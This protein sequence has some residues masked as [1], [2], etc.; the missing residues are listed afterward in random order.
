MQGIRVEKRL[1]I[2]SGEIY[3]EKD[4]LKFLCKNT[5]QKVEN[6]MCKQKYI[7][8]SIN[9]YARNAEKKFYVIFKLYTEIYENTSTNV[10]WRQKSNWYGLTF[11]RRKMSLYLKI[12]ESEGINKNNGKTIG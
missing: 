12:E 1:I 3:L 5:S 6:L 4:G 10:M 11:L 7:C 9:S 8:E 2:R